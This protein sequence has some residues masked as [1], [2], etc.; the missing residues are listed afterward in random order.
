MGAWN[1]APSYIA[2]CRSYGQI[3]VY[4]AKC[5]GVRA[6]PRGRGGACTALSAPGGP[7]HH[8]PEG[9]SPGYASDLLGFRCIFMLM[10][11]RTPSRALE[12]TLQH[13]LPGW[14]ANSWC[15][16]Q[17]LDRGNCPMW[18]RMAFL[19]QCCDPQ[20]SHSNHRG[21]ERTSVKPQKAGCSHHWQQQK[22]L[23]SNCTQCS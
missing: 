15:L 7:W 4:A 20:C 3:P 18:L 23:E 19:N 5:P 14:V 2:R 13:R 8:G 11:Q 10:W 9:E 1:R 17:A 21:E 16:G 12:A 22:W 6:G